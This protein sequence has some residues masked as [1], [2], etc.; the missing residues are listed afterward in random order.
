MS[1]VDTAVPNGHSEANSNAPELSQAQKLMQ[2]HD[3]EHQPTIEDVPDEEDLKHGEQPTSTSVLEDANG[4]S[5]APG[6][7]PPMSTISAGK[8]KEDVRKEPKID[9]QSH[10]LFPSLGGTPQPRPQ[11]QGIWGSGKASANANGTPINS[12]P[13]ASTPNSGAA[14]PLPTADRPKVNQPGQQPQERIELAPDQILKRGE[15][16]KPLPEILREIN[17]KYRSNITQSTGMGG[18]MTFTAYGPASAART[19]IKALMEQ[20]GA[21]VT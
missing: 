10:E 14:T 15:L 2:K 12:T 8:Q 3:Q 13:R 16:K 4:D 9:T 11:A 1:A 5:T 20:I 6:W 18:K 7:V 17:K 21:K 19:G